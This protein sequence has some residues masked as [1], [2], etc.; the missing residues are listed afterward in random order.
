MLRHTLK[1]RA[2]KKYKKVIVEDMCA[3]GRWRGLD[4]WTLVCLNEEFSIGE[5]RLST[6]DMRRCDG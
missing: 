3:E 2:R 1:S 6:F 4:R 5:I